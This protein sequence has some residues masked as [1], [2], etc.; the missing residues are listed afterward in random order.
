MRRIR[1]SIL[2]PRRGRSSIA[3]W[4]KAYR[5]GGIEKLLQRRH[6]G[7]STSLSEPDQDA[8][9]EKL[10]SGKWKRIYKTGYER[11]GVLS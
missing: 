3:R 9:I 1:Y 7:R 10:K 4:L 8:L 2:A 6:G 5:E 11:N